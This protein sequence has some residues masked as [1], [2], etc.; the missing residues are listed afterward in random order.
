M[1]SVPQWK[2][3]RLYYLEQRASN[4]YYTSN[5]QW[6]RKVVQWG[7]CYTKILFVDWLNRSLLNTCYLPHQVGRTEVSIFWAPWESKLRLA[8][9]TRASE[10]RSIYKLFTSKLPLVWLIVWIWFWD[11]NICLN[12]STS[13]PSLVIGSHRVDQRGWLCRVAPCPNHSSMIRH[14]IHDLEY[15]RAVTNLELL[16]MS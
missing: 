7:D 2:P 5:E 12:W 8:R 14:F 13:W 10:K 16:I 11:S 15:E 4:K 6:H 9:Q 3:W 1:Q